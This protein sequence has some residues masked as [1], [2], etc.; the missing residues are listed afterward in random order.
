MSR[1]I[2]TLALLTVAQIALAAVPA[3]AQTVGTMTAEQATVTKQ[4]AG[5]VRAGDGIA[6]GD[7]LRSNATGQG[8]IVFDD[9][10]SARLGPNADLTIDAFVYDPQRRNGTV[11]FI[12]RD[13]VARIFGGQISKRG[14]SE[15]RTPHIVLG[16]RG[17]IADIVVGA[18]TSTGTL[19]G[20][21]MTCESEGIRRTITNPGFSCSS[22]GS[23]LRIGPAGGTGGTFVDP[24]TGGGD[25]GT[26][27]PRAHCATEA[28]MNSAACR[29]RDGGLPTPNGGTQGG[30][31]GGIAGGSPGSPP[32]E[33]PPPPPPP[34][35]PQ[36]P[37]TTPTTPTTPA[38]C[39]AL[40][41]FLDQNGNCVVN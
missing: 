10:S 14:R 11:R 3:A 4:G 5:R 28:G 38:A 24:V 18:T 35:P 34:P 17:G 9:E 8:M 6:L 21:V 20:G 25:G 1:T 12:Q 41:G 15:V 22:D 40:G 31:S 30:A 23:G 26:G 29:S 13:G 19:V 33:P 36:T 2:V 27:L 16:L 37:N 32:P 7:R 39:A